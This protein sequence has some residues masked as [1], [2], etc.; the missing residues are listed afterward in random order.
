MENVGAII[1]G[2]SRGIGRATAVRLAQD[3]F[4]ITVNYSQDEEG[5]KKTV[6][7]VKDHGGE[8][9]SVQADVSDQDATKK[10]V[11]RTVEEY[12]DL[13]VLVNNAGFSHHATLDELRHE[14]WQKGID[15][16][17]TGSFNCAKAA[18]PEM[19]ELGWGRIVNI[20]SLRAMTGSDHG[21]HYASSK[22]GL[23]G[24]TKSLALELAPE[25]TVNAISP[26]YTRTP[27]TRESLEEKE[28]QITEKIPLDRVAESPEI[29]GVISFLVSHDGSYITGETINANG[30]I[31][32]R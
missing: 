5:A 2:S 6:R 28:D 27:M 31:Y 21:S 16:N 23:L 12:G 11:E 32:M 22:A 17:L 18:A 15:V 9:F 4:K 29:A 1:T 26:G 30:G 8:A 7:T 19:K 3:G 20:S 24:L 14:D 25:I 13:G 10:L